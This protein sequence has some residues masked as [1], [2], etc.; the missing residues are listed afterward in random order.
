MKSIIKK[1]IGGSYILQNNM[2]YKNVFPLKE[3][4][5]MNKT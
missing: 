4:K 2:K 3:A 5:N 1:K